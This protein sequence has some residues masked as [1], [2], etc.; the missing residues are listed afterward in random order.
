MLSPAPEKFI[1]FIKF[2][3]FINFSRPPTPSVAA[4]FKNR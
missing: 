1:T 4:W 3:N 2:I